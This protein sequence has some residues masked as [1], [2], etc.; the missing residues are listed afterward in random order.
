MT[1]RRGNY[2]FIVLIEFR[3]ELVN[4]KEIFITY[5]CIPQLGSIQHPL[6]FILTSNIL[7]YC[8]YLML[9]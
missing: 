8:I 9:N 1:S 5:K 3:L 6:A 4:D 7:S 2:I